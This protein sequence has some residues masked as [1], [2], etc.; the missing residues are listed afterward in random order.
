MTFPDAI[1]ADLMLSHVPANLRAHCE[2]IAP[3]AAGVFLRSIQCSQGHAG[4]TVTYSRAHSGDALRAY[5]IQRARSAGLVFPTKKKHCMDTDKAADAWSRIGLQKHVEGGSGRSQG[6]VLCYSTSSRATIIWTDTP[7]KILAEASRNLA[8]R[9]AL[10]SWWQEDA[11]PETERAMSPMSSNSAWPDAIEKELLLAHIPPSIRRTCQRDMT[12]YDLQVFLRGAI[13]NQG[14]GTGEVEYLYAH[15][16]SALTGF[17]HDRI[18]A[19]GLDGLQGRCAMQ[20]VAASP[21]SRI[22]A[23]GHRESS[24]Q[25][26]EGTVVCSEDNGGNETIEWSDTPTVVYVRASMPSSRRRA[27]YRWWQ[28]NAGPGEL[29]GSMGPM[30]TTSASAPMP[31]TSTERTTTGMGGGGEKM[32]TTGSMGTTTTMAK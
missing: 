27:L 8:D 32:P 15:S 20:T 26:A 3:V 10:Y 1:E 19:V 16:G 2:R 25:G 14:A 4:E 12:S 7:T 29:A 5:F 24:R 31:A 17:I 9:A 13:C 6:R 11:G 23:I 18:S 28:I 21:W 22:G 30:G